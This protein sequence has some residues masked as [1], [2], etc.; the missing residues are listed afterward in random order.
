MK[1]SASKNR[2]ILR[3]AKEKSDRGHKRGAP[4]KYKEGNRVHRPDRIG[5]NEAE[6]TAMIFGDTFCKHNINDETKNVLLVMS[7]S[8][9]AC[10]T[11]L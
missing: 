1:H 6:G 4:I 10:T 11:V 8:I 9:D 2:E 5:V 7:L 3:K